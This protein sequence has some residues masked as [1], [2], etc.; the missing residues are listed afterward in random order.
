MEEV[1]SVFGLMRLLRVYRTESGTF[2]DT[3]IAYESYIYTL[4]IVSS[5]G[6]YYR[7]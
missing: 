7:E 5:Y 6:C 3:F 2:V 4:A 1:C